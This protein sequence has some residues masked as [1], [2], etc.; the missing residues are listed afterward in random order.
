MVGLKFDS[1]LGSSI[2]LRGGGGS[3]S[4]RFGLWLFPRGVKDLGILAIL[5]C[6]LWSLLMKIQG[7]QN[8]QSDR[9]IF[10][11]V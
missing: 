4:L 1:G 10:E 2:F 6:F 7:F 9:G 11:I 3:G 5:K 8:Y